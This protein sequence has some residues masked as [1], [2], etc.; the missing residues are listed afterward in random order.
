[1]RPPCRKEELIELETVHTMKK[2]IGA[3]LFIIESAVSESATETATDKVRRLILSDTD[4]SE[5]KAS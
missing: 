3:T 4:L 1:M 2:Y 5:K